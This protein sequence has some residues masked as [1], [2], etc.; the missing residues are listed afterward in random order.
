MFKKILTIILSLV[1]MI[2]AKG[3]GLSKNYYGQ[4]NDYLQYGVGARALAMGGAYSGLANEAS[5][6][7]WNPAGLA[8]MDEFEISSMYASFFEGTSL[9]FIAS[10][11]PL[12][13]KIGTFAITDVLLY[14]G[15]FEERDY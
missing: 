13:P 8:L 11:H 6:G 7:Y 1:I 15:G 14:S 12:G 2:M 10:A 3:M 9:N 4:P 5:A